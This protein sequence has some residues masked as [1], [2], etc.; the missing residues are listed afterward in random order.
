MDHHFFTS[1]NQNLEKAGIALNDIS[2]YQQTLEDILIFL[3]FG[4]GAKVIIIF[5][6]PSKRPSVPR[7]RLF[8]W[9]GLGAY[10][11]IS[12]LLQLWPTMAIASQKVL[13]PLPLLS[14]MASYWPHHAIAYTIWSIIIQ[15]ILGIF[16]LTERE[17]L[18]GKITLV[19]SAIWSI[20]LWIFGEN[21]GG[22]THLSA[23]LVLGSPGAGFFALAISVSLLLPVSLW[24]SGLAQKNI[25]RGMAVLW[26]VATLWQLIHFNDYNAWRPLWIP[27]INGAQPAA[28]LALH[29]STQA[30][31]RSTAPVLNLI[32]VAAMVFTEVMLVLKKPNLAF[33]IVLTLVLLAFWA[34]GQG[35]GLRPAYGANLNAAPLIF[36]LFLSTFQ[37]REHY[38]A[39]RK[40]A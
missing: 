28:A 23:S 7:G 6:I 11:S 15:L 24:E 27:Y 4:I 14:G 5:V 10:W 21:F 31:L 12:A 13:S 18:T 30:L 29:N 26:A 40:T 8:L 39:K 3:W 2:L 38:I 9:Y 22:L 25:W 17:N 32:L 19:L 33:W 34:L 16:L 37:T 1:L 20:F 36:L 35:F